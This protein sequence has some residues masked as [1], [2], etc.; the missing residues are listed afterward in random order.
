[1]TTR[2]CYARLGVVTCLGLFSTVFGATEKSAAMV[3]FELEKFSVVATRTSLPEARIPASVSTVSS[4]MLDQLAA[5]D[6]GDLLRFEPLVELPF[7]PGGNDVFVPYQSPGY[8]AYSIRG[9]GGNRVLLLIDGVRQASIMTGSGGTRTDLFDPWLLSSLELL[10]GTASSLYGSDALGGVVALSTRGAN[11]PTRNQ[12]DLGFRYD[13]STE[14]TAALSVATFA[15]G[16][17]SGRIGLVARDQA[18][19]ANFG[20]V[21]ANPERMRS[22]HGLASLD[23]APGDDA[24]W[25]FTA[26]HFERDHRYDL[27]SA[28]GFEPMLL[29]DV[30]EVSFTTV[31]SRDRL[32]LAYDRTV[33]TGFWEA[34]HGLTYYQ[35]NATHSRS[36]QVGE[37]PGAFGGGRDRRDLI[38]FIQTQVG[39]EG[40]GTARAS[41]GAGDHRMVF[42]VSLETSTAENG[43]L[44]IDER[45]VYTEEDLIG[46]APSRTGR[47]ALFWQDEVS[48]GSWLLVAGLRLEHYAIEPENSEAY[49]NRLNE[50]LPPGIEPLRAVDY[51]LTSWAP[52]VALSYQWTGTLMSY[53]RFARGYRQPTAEEFTGLFVHGAEFI[54]LPNPDLREEASDA[55]EIGVKWTSPR[56]EVRA[57][58]FQTDYEGF[59][60][61]VA[62]GERLDPGN[63]LS[64]QIQQTRNVA[65]ARIQGFEFTSRWQLLDPKADP[66]TRLH[67]TA[68]VGQ[69]WGEERDT[70]EPLAS[71]SPLKAVGGLGWEAVDGRWNLLLT[72]TYRARHH[73]PPVDTAFVPGESLVWDLSGAI[74]LKRWLM[75]EAGLRNFS[76]E[77]YHLWANSNQGIH[78]ADEPGRSTLPGR[79]VF[80]G[81]RLQF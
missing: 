38:D 41:W 55:W 69:A 52:S 81:L 16:P 36:R 19:R 64:L 58:I 1:M 53:A 4:A 43:F 54:V 40:Q 11:A 66:A 5:S 39:F 18:E 12:L 59:F 10:K 80:A 30:T 79:H 62:T 78:F 72:A 70:G 42:G 3:A 8:S 76:D 48:W 73:E 7:D 21:P 67:F 60:E 37:P 6:A 56:V 63:P 24:S 27:D 32:S 75:L 20:E 31:Q 13:D 33:E 71:V 74:R 57:S 77:R 9:V 23:F 17:W 65:D 45:P 49:L 2:F 28:E 14:G 61:T 29:L 22:W 35:R 26:E 15:E 51:E 68:T 44:R 46:M 34:W 47:G 25:R 50:R